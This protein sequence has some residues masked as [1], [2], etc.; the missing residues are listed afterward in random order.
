MPFVKDADETVLWEGRS[1]FTQRLKTVTLLAV[2]FIAIGGF[3]ATQGSAV[4]LA[5]SIGSVW[6][7]LPS[8]L[9]YVVRGNR[10]YVTNRRVVREK[11]PFLQQLEHQEIR[12]V[13]FPIM[14]FGFLGLWTLYIRPKYPLQTYYIVFGYLKK[15]EADIVKEFIEEAMQRFT[16]SGEVP[17]A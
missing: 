8:L 2:S 17:F 5:I 16:T 7:V 3:L 13:S 9:Y 1:T 10:Y 14:N 15:G 6:F 12:R 11:F 4:A